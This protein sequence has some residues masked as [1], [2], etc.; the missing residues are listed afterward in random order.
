MNKRKNEGEINEKT[1]QQ[2]P[3]D[4]IDLNEIPDAV[5]LK[6]NALCCDDLFE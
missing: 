1:K 3:N 4:D 6:L 2:K 5:I